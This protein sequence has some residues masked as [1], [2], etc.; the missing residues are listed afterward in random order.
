[1]I[2]TADRF[3]R[4]QVVEASTKYFLTTAS[5]DKSGASYEC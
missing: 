2:G 4:Q 5:S 3:E 1:L